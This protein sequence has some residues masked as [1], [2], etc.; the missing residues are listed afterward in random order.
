MKTNKKI[1]ANKEIRGKM[2]EEEKYMNNTKQR[3]NIRI[4]A[5][6][7]NESKNQTKPDK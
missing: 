2:M 5:Q 1:K 4:F 3:K 7:E 6:Y